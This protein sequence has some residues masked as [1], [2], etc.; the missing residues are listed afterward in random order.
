MACD[1]AEAPRSFC[2]AYQGKLT[3]QGETVF[4]ETMILLW[5]VT[6]WKKVQ[7]FKTDRGQPIQIA[8]KG[9]AVILRD[10][11]NIRNTQKSTI[12]LLTGTE[13]KEIMKT[14]CQQ[15]LTIKSVCSQMLWKEMA[16]FA[17]LL[18]PLKFTGCQMKK[19]WQEFLNGRMW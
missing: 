19:C 2:S 3:V 13:L 7:T 9:V 14:E 5:A 18:F 15:I 4:T 12:C 17:R 10:I 16:V 8:R 11:L 1:E 6:G